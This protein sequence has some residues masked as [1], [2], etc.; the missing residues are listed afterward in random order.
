M[1]ALVVTVG[2]ALGADEHDVAALTHALREAGLDV[3]G[4]FAVDD[5][6]ATLECALTTGGRAGG[7]AR[8][9]RRA[10]AR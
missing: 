7:S 8:S 3:T 4:R 6:E 1:S 2:V 5:D 10:R 9:A